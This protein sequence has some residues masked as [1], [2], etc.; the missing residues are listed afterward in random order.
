[1]QQRPI[2]TSNKKGFLKTKMHQIDFYSITLSS[3]FA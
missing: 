2:N 1:M 3:E